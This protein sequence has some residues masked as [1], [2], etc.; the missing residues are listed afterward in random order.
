MCN[1]QNTISD[2][3]SCISQASEFQLEMRAGLAS[4]MWFISFY[5]KR[6]V[7]FLLFVNF[8]KM[9]RINKVKKCTQRKWI[10]AENYE[11]IM[12]LMLVEAPEFALFV[13]KLACFNVS[14]TSRRK[15]DKFWL[16]LRI[17]WCML[18][19]S[20]LNTLV[21]CCSYLS[22]FFIDKLRS[23]LSIKLSNQ[24]AMVC[25]FSMGWERIIF[26]FIDL[27]LEWN[28]ND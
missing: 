3:H 9:V 7:A 13:F 11:T 4:A 26:S 22:R 6:W 12:S 2:N 1:S 25:C 21:I 23:T 24:S 18:V 19:I 14:L 17:E 15:S 28:R 5:L 16:N 10:E 27:K 8:T 20:K